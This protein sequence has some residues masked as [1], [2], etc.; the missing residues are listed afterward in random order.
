[1]VALKL[2]KLGMD[3][4][5][6]I[7]R[8]ESERQALAMLS[9]PNVARVLDA[10]ATD[11][12]R[13]YFVMEFVPGEPIT[14]YC[15]KN[16]LN[17]RQRLELFTQACE[18][19]E[20]AHQKA[21]VHRDLKPGN[22]LVTLQD[23]APLVKVIDFGVAKA[24]SQRLTERTLFTERGQLIGTPE[25]MSP[26]QAEMGGLDV[27]TRSDI[28]SLGVVLYEL[29]TGTLPFEPKTLRSAAYN[30]IQRIIRETDPPRPSARLSS[31]GAAAADDVA[32]RRR[33]P[34]PALARQLR[35]ELEWL[36]LK[37]MR[38]DRAHRYR[39][40]SEL[41]QDIRNYLEQ[42]P[43]IA[44]PPTA[45]Y[46]V[47][48]FLRRHRATV[49]AVVAVLLV[50]VLGV[51]GTT[52]G[53]VRAER[54]RREAVAMRDSLAAVNEFLT[55][56][57]IG[58]ADPAVTRGRELSVREALD[59]AAARIGRK[60]TDRP[61][62]EANVRASVAGA[63]AAVG[64]AD[65]A[66]PHARSA[67]EARRKLLGE[68]HP[69]T[70]R[71]QSRVGQLL[72]QTGRAADA[73]PLWRDALA[74]ARRVL[75]EDDRLT[76][77]SYSNLGGLLQEQGKFADAEPLHRAAVAG[78]RRTLGDAHPDT[79]MSINNL[80][81]L[82]YLRG[83]LADAERLHREALAGRRRAL[84]DD[85]PHTLTSVGNVGAVL[86]AK[87]KLDDAEPFYKE[88][89]DVRRRVLGDDHPD[90]LIALSNMAYLLFERGRP[91]EAAVAFREAAD[92]FR[93]VLG[94]DHPQTLVSVH[95]LASC[96]KER[97]ELDAAEALLEEVV[98]RRR[99][100]LGDG[101]ADTLASRHALVGLLIAQGELSR[102]EPQAR[103]VLEGFRAGFGEHHPGTVAATRNLAKLLQAQGRH[104]D[105]ERLL[106]R[107]L[108]AVRATSG[109]DH[110]TTLR[111]MQALVVLLVD[112][113]KHA[114]AE[115]LAAELYRR[116][117]HA[118]LAPK[119]RAVARAWHGPC[120]TKLGRFSD[121]EPPLR[122]A[123]ARLSET[124]QRNSAAMRLVVEA[125][126]DACANTGRADEADRWRAELAALRAA[127][128]P[129]TSPAT[130]PAP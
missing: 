57:V 67:L 126:G 96:L 18:A 58:S 122:E 32:R 95:N 106:R 121:A 69:E 33:T 16:H 49:A 14:A 108:G 77:N 1:L 28:Y 76:L 7:A 105:A 109:D 93:R 127:T 54:Q 101:H 123:Y 39:T 88:T 19:I 40:A 70:I 68:D 6:V 3:T 59:N 72:L 125:L 15:D 29:L 110:P 56:D 92:R 41:A 8:F 91:D 35:N 82:L 129:A 73:E 2:I 114:D 99:R 30:E 24:V 4:R 119:E 71:A 113:S 20:H 100:V 61:L 13:P 52:V 12:G 45:A 87:G 80:A 130:Q 102:A 22:I 98:A 10:G 21:L 27:D 116:A 124:D 5:E 94:D 97:G 47:R 118:Q 75:G 104:A 115:P 103:E 85:H 17:V 25:Y 55:D 89:L 11:A 63:Y 23:G 38:K 50:L 44:G 117:A 62:V 83:R 84:G 53:L 81:L 43:L 107:A 36:P 31:L 111:V 74:R 42:R 9:H 120:L 64:R 90:T 66:L 79:L 65:L 26:E 34:L 78:H 128:R 60:F 86:A 37:A 48:K 46:Q 112:Q 51:I